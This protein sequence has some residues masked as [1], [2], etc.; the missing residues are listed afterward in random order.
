MLGSLRS[1][2]DREPTGSVANG[3]ELQGQI[4]RAVALSEEGRRAD[5]I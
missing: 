2:W 3:D 5:L 1:V 4:P